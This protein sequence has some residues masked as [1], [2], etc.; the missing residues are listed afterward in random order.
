MGPVANIALCIVWLFR[1]IYNKV[2]TNLH[3]Q[4]DMTVF[5]LISSNGL[6]YAHVWFKR[7]CTI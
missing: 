1:L 6:I 5:E 4:I 2:S 7:Q 3:P